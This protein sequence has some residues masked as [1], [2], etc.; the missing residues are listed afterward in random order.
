MI[1]LRKMNA[2]EYAAYC[3]I[4]IDDYGRDLADNEGFSLDLA[5]TKAR[6]EL[7][8]TLPD[9][10]DTTNEILLS[11]EFSN[12]GIISVVGFL[13]HSLNIEEHATFISDFY[14]YE[15]YRGL[16]YGKQAMTC[17]ERQLY[18]QNITRVGLRVAF[19]NPRALKLYQ[20]CGF[21]IS[22]FDMIKT[23]SKS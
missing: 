20:A 3:E 8:E 6:N 16:G 5:L 23:L 15:Q 22:G 10:L 17:F 19:N 11:I 13:W 1:R 18:A 2:H 9:G 7:I 21:K 14:I 12:M 4:F